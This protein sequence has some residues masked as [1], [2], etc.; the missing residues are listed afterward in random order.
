MLIVLN[1][2]HGNSA[3]ATKLVTKRKIN[4][5]GAISGNA[6]FDGS[7]DVTITTRQDNIAVLTGTI[8]ADGSSNYATKSIN[9][10]AG[11]SN[12]NCVVLSVM[13]ELQNNVTIWGY[14]TT[15]TSSSI[16]GGAISKMVSLRDGDIL[17]GIRRIHMLKDENNNITEIMDTLNN[18]THS[19]KIVLMKI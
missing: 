3:T 10:P 7:E 19:Y 14:G 9:Y 18:E 17:L 4:L 16:M 6:K 11:F 1:L 15:Y 12:S 5:I 2:V 8:T 13:L